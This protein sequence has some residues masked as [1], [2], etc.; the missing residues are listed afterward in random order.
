MADVLQIPI[1]VPYL[2]F[3]NLWL[4]EGTPLTL[5]DTGPANSESS[6]ALDAGLAAHGHTVDDIELILITH[7][8]L[9]HAG[10]AQSISERSGAPI[11]AHRG[12]AQWGL[13]YHDRAR[14]EHRFSEALML[15][16]G[17]PE[18]LVAQTKP[19]FEDIIANSEGFTTDR[20]LSD[21]DT[22]AAGGRTLRVVF[23]PGHSTTDTLFIDDDNG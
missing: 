16:H 10:M 1:P 2:G 12:T 18:A 6:A 19:F 9:D 3:V 5:I 17:V 4:L 21:G 22:I 20:V 23:R 8:H 13:A 14:A 11:A 15:E 7:H